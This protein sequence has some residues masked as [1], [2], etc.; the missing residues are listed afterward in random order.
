VQIV[1]Y[2]TFWPELPG[3]K[4]GRNCCKTAAGENPANDVLANPAG[5][6]IKFAVKKENCYKIL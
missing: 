3:V 5:K 2:L 1:V 4:L 6:F